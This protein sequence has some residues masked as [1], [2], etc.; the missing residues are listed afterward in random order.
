MLAGAMVLSWH[1]HGIEFDTGAGLIA[2]SC[3]VWGI[4]NNITRKLSSADPVLTATIKA[5]SRR[6]KY[7][8]RHTERRSLTSGGHHRCRAHR[9]L[10]LVSGSALCSLSSLSDISEPPVA[11]PIFR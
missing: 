2:A 8:A 5:G 6:G 4:D 1:G 3:L 10:L 7:R 9:G 11:G